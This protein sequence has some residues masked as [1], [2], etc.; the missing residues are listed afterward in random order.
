MGVTTSIIANRAGD[1]IDV[2]NSKLPVVD[3]VV[4]EI[5]EGNRYFYNQSK[6]FTNAEVADYVIE[7]GDNCIRFVFDL[8]STASGFTF[9]TYEDVTVAEDGTELTILNSNR[10]SSNTSDCT[11]RLGATVTAITD[12]VVIRT[13]AV[14]TD[15]SPVARLAGTVDA[16]H[17][18]VLKPNKKYL[19][20]ITNLATANTINVNIGWL[21]AC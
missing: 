9:A 3:T 20:R 14:G 12:E 10:E 1:E 2:Q 19:I 18:L 13:G 8:S 6:T 4:Y 5:L 15:G 16:Q 11:L 21:E 7:V 17:E